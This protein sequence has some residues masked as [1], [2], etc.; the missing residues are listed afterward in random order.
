[1]RAIPAVLIFI[2]AFSLAGCA[3]TPVGAACANHVNKGM[4]FDEVVA[5]LGRPDSGGAQDYGSG[6]IY[7]A[8]WMSTSLG[9]VKSKA[10]IAMVTF[11]DGKV[12]SYFC[13]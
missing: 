13:Q 7:T 3:T 2:F 9:L 11:K 10:S 12:E 1:M 5:V 4:S 6:K 8:R